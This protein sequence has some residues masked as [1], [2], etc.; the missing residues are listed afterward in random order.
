MAQHA[1]DKVREL[2]REA[3]G[4]SKWIEE[5][6]KLVTFTE[7]DSRWLKADIEFHLHTIRGDVRG[8]LFEMAKASLETFVAQL[9]RDLQAELVRRQEERRAELAKEACDE[10]RSVLRELGGES[11]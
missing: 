5:G 6:G 1:I 7:P 3:L 4:H 10:A 2:D 11:A 9:E 8:H